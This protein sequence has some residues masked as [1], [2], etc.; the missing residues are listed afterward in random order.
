MASGPYL[1]GGDVPIVHFTHEDT[2]AGA[3]GDRHARLDGR[4]RH[5]AARAALARHLPCGRA[6]RQGARAP[7]RGPRAQQHLRRGSVRRRRRQHRAHA[8]DPDF[9]HARGVACAG[10][11]VSGAAGGGAVQL[12]GHG[13]ALRATGPERDLGRPDAHGIVRGRPLAEERPARRRVRASSSPTRSRSTSPAFS[14][15]LPDIPPDADVVGMQLFA[16]RLALVAALA[17]GRRGRAPRAPT[18]RSGTV[19]PGS[20]STRSSG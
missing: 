13:A 11:A 12:A 4:R 19:P 17:P 15:M 7:C 18:R 10:A 3:R 20:G 16:K 1:E 8:A 6:L 9:V 14:R 5:E 2:G